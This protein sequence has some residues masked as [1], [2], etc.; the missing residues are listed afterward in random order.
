MDAKHREN[1]CVAWCPGVRMIDQDKIHIIINLN[2]LD[3]RC[4]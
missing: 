3:A 1:V 2:L 4:T